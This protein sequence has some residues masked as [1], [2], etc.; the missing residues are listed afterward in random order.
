LTPGVYQDVD[1]YGAVPV[2]YVFAPGDYLAMVLNATISGGSIDS[3]VT[4]VVGGTTG[5]GLTI[6]SDILGV[7]GGGVDL[8]PVLAAIYQLNSSLQSNFTYMNEQI[9][10][11]NATMQ[12]NVTSILQNVTYTQ[13]YLESSIFPMLNSTYQNTVTM[14]ASLGVIQQNVNATLTIVNETQQQIINITSGVDELVNKS[15]RIRAWVTV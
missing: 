5:A 1:F 3:N 12:V 4:L 14:L 10:S 7:T 11:L 15:R 13:L 6:G 8:N 9:T 2:D